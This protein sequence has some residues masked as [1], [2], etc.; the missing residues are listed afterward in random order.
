[1]IYETD[2]YE[3]VDCKMYMLDTRKGVNSCIFRFAGLPD[4]LS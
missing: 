2:K 1:M 3:V 4:A